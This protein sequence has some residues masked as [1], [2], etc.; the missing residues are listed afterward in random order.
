MQILHVCRRCATSRGFH[1]ARRYCRAFKLLC[2]AS[3][4]RLDKPGERSDDVGGWGL[5][6]VIIITH[7]RVNVS[8]PT[9]G[10]RKPGA[11]RLENGPSC[12]VKFAFRYN[13]SIIV[14]IRHVVLLVMRVS[15]CAVV[16]YNTDISCA[17]YYY[18]HDWPSRRRTIVYFS[19]F[20]VA[21]RGMRRID[22][23][24]KIGTRLVLFGKR[25]RSLK[26]SRLSR[27]RKT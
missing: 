16:E 6:T 21:Y 7:V 12:P 2:D 15:A 8:I 22:E 9:C 5:Y 1:G 3:Y 20:V 24:D 10:K 23:Y 19:R 17:W 14:L 27:V 25:R 26:N 11:L 4:A 13:N 18:S